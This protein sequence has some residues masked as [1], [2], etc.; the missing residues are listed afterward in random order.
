[1]ELGL[2]PWA[3]IYKEEVTER[4]SVEAFPLSLPQAY[5]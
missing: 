4:Q 2:S 1:M 3:T 5:M